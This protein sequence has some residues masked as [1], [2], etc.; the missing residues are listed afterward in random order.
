MALNLVPLINATIVTGFAL[1]IMFGTLGM[2]HAGWTRLILAHTL[3]ALPIV[4]LIILPRLRSMDKSQYDAAC[5]LCAKPT[6]AFFSV[7]IPQIMPAMFGAFLVGFTLSVDE[8]IITN[9]N[10]AGIVTLPTLVYAAT[11]RPM[12]P[13]FRALAA[14]VFL[15]VI[16]VLLLV[17]W[18]MSKKKGGK[19]EKIS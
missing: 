7:I 14:I 18:R 6:K 5:D 16:M 12:P 17:N 9:Y 1:M 3:V 2:Q 13:A 19:N 4:M 15:T 10:N 11:R 8:F